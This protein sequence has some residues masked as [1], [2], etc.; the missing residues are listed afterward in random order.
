MIFYL[1]IDFYG[2]NAGY[3]LVNN[4]T[5]SVYCQ[6]INLSDFR[7]LSGF[8]QGFIVRVYVG[9]ARVCRG[10]RGTPRS[11]GG[12]GTPRSAGGAAVGGAHRG[13]RGNWTSREFGRHANSD[14]TRIRTSR[15]GGGPR[16]RGHRCS[17][18]VTVETSVPYV[19][20]PYARGVKGASF[21]PRTI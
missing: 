13:R 16:R 14:V 18:R 10:R 12:A 21:H 5:L 7:V 8:C 20:V 11:A 15:A 1:T 17:I 4:S 19:T 2:F 9:Y 3:F 6:T